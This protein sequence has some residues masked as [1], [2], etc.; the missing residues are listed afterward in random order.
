[1]KSL[2]PIRTL[3]LLVLV[4]LLVGLG[5]AA[6]TGPQSSGESHFG[7]TTKAFLRVCEDGQ[8]EQGDSCECSVCTIA[9][10]DVNDCAERILGAGKDAS[11]LPD[12]VRCQ[13]P[14][15]APEDGSDSGP[16]SGAICE[17][18]CESDEDCEFL[19]ESHDGEPHICRDG[20]CRTLETPDDPG[21]PE[22]PA[23]VCPDGRELIPGILTDDGFGFCLD[24]TEVTVAAYRACVDEGMCTAPDAGNFLTAGR[25]DH[26]VH[27]VEVLQAEEYCAFVGARL[28]SQAEWLD[29]AARGTTDDSYPWG[30]D[31]PLAGDMPELVCG[32][33]STDTCAVGT[34]P[35]GATPEGHLDLV[36]NVA[37]IVTTED[38]VCAAGGSFESTATELFASACEEITGAV[39]T[40]GFRCAQGL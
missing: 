19:D 33:E 23:I 24:L 11:E 3:L 39:P 26:P 35:A 25:E 17:V 13:V 16:Q 18:T 37:E 8:C 15:C 1:M 12:N 2:P 30:D 21:T 7:Q 5:F 22:V 31:E 38:A 28:P 6:C 10:G 34:Y 36:G 9:C 27:V 40:V 14:Q 4:L 32:L 20:A 29:A